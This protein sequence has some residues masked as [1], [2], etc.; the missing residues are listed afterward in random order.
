MFFKFVIP[1]AVGV[2]TV[3]SLARAEQSGARIGH[4]DLML[5][6]VPPPSVGVM[7][8]RNAAPVPPGPLAYGPAFGRRFPPRGRAPEMIGIGI[9]RQGE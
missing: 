9:H 4:S 3:V 6:R 2:L 1:L 5:S 7:L 8:G